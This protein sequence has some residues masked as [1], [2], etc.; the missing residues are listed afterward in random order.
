MTS[1]YKIERWNIGVRIWFRP[2]FW[3]VG[4]VRGD[5]TVTYELGPISIYTT[6]PETAH[7]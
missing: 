3:S 6:L 7:A 4:V 1:T 2:W 5:H